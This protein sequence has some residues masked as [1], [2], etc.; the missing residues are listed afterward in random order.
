VI[1]LDPLQMKQ[2]MLI[3]TYHVLMDEDWLGDKVHVPYTSAS[4]ATG[5]NVK[6]CLF[7][8]LASHPSDQSIYK[9]TKQGEQGNEQTP[10]GNAYMC[11]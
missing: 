1:S 9:P 10:N 11:S 8:A 7:H 2:T 5:R 6:R 3:S 4:H